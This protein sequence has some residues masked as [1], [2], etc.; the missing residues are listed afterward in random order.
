MKLKPP[1]VQVP[2][3]VVDDEALDSSAKAT[4]LALARFAND[5]RQCYPSGTTIARAAGLGRS[6]TFRALA[7][8]ERKGYLRRTPRTEPGSKEKASTQYTLLVGSPAAGQPSSPAAGRGSPGKG[9]RVVP[10]RDRNYIRRELDVAEP[11]AT[12]ADVAAIRSAVRSGSNGRHARGEG[13][14]HGSK[15][16]AE[17]TVG[18]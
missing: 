4:Y 3:A 1:F 13:G 2:R 12:S 16:T 6:T 15:A 14:S 9:F 10:Q 7:E 18:L 8:L 17:E 5:E 11:R